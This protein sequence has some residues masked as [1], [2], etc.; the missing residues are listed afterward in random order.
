MSIYAC[1]CTC[2]YIYIHIWHD[3]HVQEE[4][5]E[6]EADMDEEVDTDIPEGEDVLSDSGSDARELM[7]CDL[8]VERPLPPS[9]PIR[10]GQ[11]VADRLH[12]LAELRQQMDLLES[13]VSGD[14]ELLAYG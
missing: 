9:S 4:A 11:R 10:H 7:E 5:E 3:R 12:R 8:D 2:A 14:A 13:A 1:A 6:E